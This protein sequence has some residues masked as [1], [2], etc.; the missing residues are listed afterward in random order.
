MRQFVTE[1]F[2]LLA[3]F[4]GA[5]C[6]SRQPIVE[7]QSNKTNNSSNI[8]QATNK[9]DSLDNS[10]SVEKPRDTRPLIPI[11]END[12]SPK[13]RALFSPSTK[14]SS[15][16]DEEWWLKYLDQHPEMKYSQITVG[17][18]DYI[19]DIRTKKL[20][21]KRKAESPTNGKIQNEF[22]GD[23]AEIF[24][25]TLNEQ[26]DDITQG[27]LEILKFDGKTW[28][29]IATAELDYNC[30]D[31]RSVPKKIQNCLEIECF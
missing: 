4:G 6:A 12:L 3:V 26:M 5:G 15:A 19:F 27:G 8:T 25:T 1:I 11:T 20:I 18:T 28:K 22:C 17:A 31:L 21:G 10:A 9:S 14:S 24:T 2:V 13:L 29:T 7:A 16:A 30:K 23:Y